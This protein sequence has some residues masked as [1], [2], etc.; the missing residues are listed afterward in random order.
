MKE[1]NTIII[2]KTEETAQEM[3]LQQ[4]R[5]HSDESQC[6]LCRTTWNTKN[7]YSKRVERVTLVMIINTIETTI[8]QMGPEKVFHFLSLHFYGIESYFALMKFLAL[9]TMIRT[10]NIYVLSPSKHREYLCLIF[11]QTEE[12]SVQRNMYT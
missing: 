2:I 5:G 4:R 8:W 10:R 3:I 11:V 1:S 9:T 6:G 7:I 12:N